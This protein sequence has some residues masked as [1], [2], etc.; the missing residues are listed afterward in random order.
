MKLPPLTIEKLIITSEAIMVI[1]LKSQQDIAGRQPEGDNLTIFMYN[2]RIFLTMFLCIY[3][4]HFMNIS[5]PK[6]LH[7][8]VWA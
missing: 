8:S 6:I 7:N 4:V 2:M 1:L 5:I 3:T